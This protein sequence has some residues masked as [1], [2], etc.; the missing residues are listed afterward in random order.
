MGRRGDDLR[1]PLGQ[2][3]HAAPSAAT[4]EA[5]PCWVMVGAGDAPGAVH[6]WR[7]DPRSG[8]WEALVVAWLPARVVAPRDATD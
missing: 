3:G 6:A 4:D 2:R 5:R 7:Q 1:L 8:Q